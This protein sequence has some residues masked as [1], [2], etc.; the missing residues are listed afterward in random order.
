MSDT[1]MLM[2]QYVAGPALCRDTASLMLDIHFNPEVKP[3]AIKNV[4]HKPGIV[5][6]PGIT[7]VYQSIHWKPR[8]NLSCDRCEHPE[9]LRPINQ[10]YTVTVVTGDGCFS[11][12]PSRYNST[13]TT[14]PKSC[15][16]KAGWKNTYFTLP[17]A[18]L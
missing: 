11:T 15:L 14:C 17:A 8:Y 4:D 3:V 7:T 12:A 16:A 13:T 5:L 2:L 6:D 9:L 18:G 1:G 10:E